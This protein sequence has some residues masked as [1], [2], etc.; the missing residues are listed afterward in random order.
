MP[1][2]F[3]QP[4]LVLLVGLEHVV[5]VWPCLAEE[6]LDAYRAPFPDFNSR[7]H[8]LE[9]PRD[10]PVGEQHPSYGAIGEIEDRIQGRGGRLGFLDYEHP[11]FE[12]AEYDLTATLSIAPWE[13]ALGT[14][15]EFETLD[16][17]IAVKIPAGVQSGQKLRVRER[18]LRR[19]REA[20]GDLFL[21]LQIV[22]PKP[23]SKK[24]R[25]LFQELAKVSDFAPRADR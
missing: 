6:L 8:V 21:K 16:G 11:V 3:C 2:C 23:L 24:E 25:K 13:A 7:C 4:L 18:G 1:F 19:S 12:V 15:I 17:E 10:L 9:F 22:V 5:V 20:R 14:E